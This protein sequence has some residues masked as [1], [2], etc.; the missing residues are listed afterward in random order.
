MIKSAI[1]RLLVSAVALWITSLLAQQLGL[2]LIIE[3][4]AGAVLAVL[5]LSLVNALIR[6]M[7]NMMALPLRCLTFGLIGIVINAVLF[8]V[9]GQLNI[10]GF[11]VEGFLAAL[12]G[13][14]VMGVVSAILNHFVKVKRERRG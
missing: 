5:A 11:K 14:V 3:G 12:F 2:K 9:V 8:L 7:V 4:A 10:P 6:P 13:S 1:L